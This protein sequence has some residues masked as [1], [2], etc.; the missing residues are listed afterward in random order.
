MNNPFVLPGNWYKGNLHT[1]TTNSDGKMAPEL[2]V[3]KY[4]EAGYHFLALTDHWKVTTPTVKPGNGFLLLKGLEYDVWKTE[5][6]ETYHIVAIEPNQ[7]LDIDRKNVPTQQIIEMLNATGAV[8]FLAH[9]YWSSLTAK[10]AVELNNYLGVEVYNH[11]CELEV[12]KGTSSIHWDDLL[13]RG[14]KLYGFAVDDAHERIVDYCGGWVMVKAKE[15]TK[16][17]ICA[18]LKQGM[19]YA[20]NGPEIKNI[21]IQGKKVYVECSPV[22][23]INFM[24][25]GWTG[26]T[27]WDKDRK[28][29][30]SA[31]FTVGDRVRYIRIECI[32]TSGKIAW[33]NPFYF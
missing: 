13:V 27:V 16:E 6:N 26:T 11:G 3:Q 1:H 22:N 28:P 10:D 19:F 7:L 18:A 15:L 30:T 20:S 8:V 31:E 23:R 33:S 17:S 24:G 21:E 29:L 32:D 12:A 5:L 14:K 25:N 4:A 9:P 2:L